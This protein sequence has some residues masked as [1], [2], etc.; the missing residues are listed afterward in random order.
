MEIVQASISSGNAPSG[1][2]RCNPYPSQL[3]HCS[4]VDNEMTMEFALETV[5]MIQANLGQHTM[6]KYIGV[7]VPFS[8]DKAG[9]SALGPY[10]LSSVP[11]AVYVLVYMW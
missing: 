4:L 8:W 5:W 9:C 11:V 2:Y 7:L 10:P 1:M 6:Y 3:K